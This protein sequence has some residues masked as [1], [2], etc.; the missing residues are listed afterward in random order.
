MDLRTVLDIPRTSFNAQRPRGVAVERKKKLDRNDRMWIIPR[1][2][3]AA[4]RGCSECGAREKRKE[5][6][7]RI[8]EQEEAGREREGAK[9]TSLKNGRWTFC[10]AKR[11]DAEIRPTP[12]PVLKTR[13]RMTVTNSTPTDSLWRWPVA[14]PTTRFAIISML[15]APRFRLLRTR[16]PLYINGESRASSFPAF[17]NWTGYLRTPIESQGRAF[18]KARAISAVRF[19][20]LG[21]F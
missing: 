3:V 15:P 9:R 6:K 16:W 21:A 14:G 19:L 13:S 17:I 1:L 7:R 4:N 20:F 12:N 10:W 11:Y 8:N 5:R 18:N 2:P